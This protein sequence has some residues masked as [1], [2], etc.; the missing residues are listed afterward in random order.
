MS[1][2]KRL[3][4]DRCPTCDKVL[5]T[6]QSNFIKAIVIKSCPENHYQKEFHP[7]LETYIV[8]HNNTKIH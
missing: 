5:E 8:S 7:A 1:F 4:I 6:N 3:F 2:L